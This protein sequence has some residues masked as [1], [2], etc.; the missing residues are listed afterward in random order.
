M[1]R[2][3]LFDVFAFPMIDE[4]TKDN[5]FHI[6]SSNSYFQP[7]IS[8]HCLC[9]TKSV[10]VILPLEDTRTWVTLLMTDW[11]S[12]VLTR[13]RISTWFQHVRQTGSISIKSINY[14]YQTV[15]Y[16]DSDSGSKFASCTSQIVMDIQWEVIE[17][18]V[19]P[20]LRFPVKQNVYC[21]ET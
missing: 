5:T 6:I 15:Y 16:L 8:Q 13:I 1:I 3:I 12:R 2:Y 7:T 19:F 11:F 9:L 21:N 14:L 10:A 20:C 18:A 4:E 17:V